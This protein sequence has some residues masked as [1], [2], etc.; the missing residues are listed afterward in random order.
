MQL[1]E[2]VLKRQ[3]E[4]EV[5]QEKKLQKIKQQEEMRQASALELT[6]RYEKAVLIEQNKYEE[7]KIKEQKLLQKQEDIKAKMK[8]S[9]YVLVY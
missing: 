3:Q 7:G 4:E 2:E 5:E 1:A 8:D 9:R 6:K